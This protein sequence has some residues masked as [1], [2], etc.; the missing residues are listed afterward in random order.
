MT[1]VIK[2][3]KS[4]AT[5]ARPKID[6]LLSA[7]SLIPSYR[8]SPP[9]RDRTGLNHDRL[10]IMMLSLVKALGIEERCSRVIVP[11]G[12]GS[13]R[14]FWKEGALLVVTETRDEGSASRV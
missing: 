6:G 4:V 12:V 9:K 11:V 3:E 10:S 5:R 14:F 2:S 8:Y 7:F 1:I 13:Q